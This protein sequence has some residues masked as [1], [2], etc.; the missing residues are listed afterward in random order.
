MT[1]RFSRNIECLRY[2]INYG[3][4]ILR[5]D[6]PYWL[7]KHTVNHWI[8]LEFGDEGPWAKTRDN[9]KVGERSS[10][11]KTDWSLLHWLDILGLCV[12]CLQLY[13]AEWSPLATT[14]LTCHIVIYSFMVRIFKISSRSN[15]QVNSTGL[16]AIIVTRASS[17]FAG[18]R[19]Y[20]SKLIIASQNTF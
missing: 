1:L 13:T 9:Y 7:L 19:T 10:M 14:P 2:L 17:P 8:K 20:P 5:S 18:V 6:H 4:R 11:W 16:L 15:L 3:E 12:W